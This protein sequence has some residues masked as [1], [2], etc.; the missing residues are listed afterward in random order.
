MPTSLPQPT[1]SRPLERIVGSGSVSILDLVRPTFLRDWFRRQS[2]NF[3]KR[4]DVIADTG[5]HGRSDAQRLVDA[6]EVVVHEVNSKGVNVIL[7]FLRE[8]VSKARETAQRHAQRQ[9]RALHVTCRNVRQIRVSDLRRLRRTDDFIRAVFALATFVRLVFAVQLH[10]HGVVHVRAEHVFDRIGVDLVAIRS[11][12]H[13]MR[14]ARVQ[15]SEESLSGPSA[16]S[17]DH[18]RTHELGIG[19]KRRPR[20]NVADTKRAL[21][22][23]RD[24]LFLRADEGPYFIALHAL[25]RQVAQRLVLILGAG[26]AYV[27]QKPCDGVLTGASQARY[28][29][30]RDAL[31]H[32]ADDLSALRYWHPVHM[33]IYT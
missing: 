7:D 25:A 31:D 11:E 17:A 6:P 16:A 21:E 10:E 4:P 28:R 3:F 15:I 33:D 23:L 22:F 30:D 18:P 5:F 14:E 13:A 8:S 19:T 24:V 2:D 12:L 1:R 32:H 20:P 27:F 26:L 9:I 29:P